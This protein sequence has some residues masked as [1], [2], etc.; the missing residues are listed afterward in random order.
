MLM[1]IQ[2]TQDLSFQLRLC[3]EPSNINPS[4]QFG[5]FIPLSHWLRSLS[6]RHSEISVTLVDRGKRRKLTFFQIYSLEAV[7]LTFKV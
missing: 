4:N 6:A 1:Y 2:V 5:L 3:A 7:W